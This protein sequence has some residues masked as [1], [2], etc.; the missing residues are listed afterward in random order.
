MW[1]GLG[2]ATLFVGRSAGGVLSQARPEI[3]VFGA[4]DLASA[5][6]DIAAVREG[7]RRARFTVRRF[8]AL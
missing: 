1:R 7:L 2:R 8:A 6:K 3:T 4:A 5:L